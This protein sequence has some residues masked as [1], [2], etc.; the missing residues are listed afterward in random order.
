MKQVNDT[1]D[2]RRLLL[3][4]I[5][6]VRDGSVDPRTAGAISSLSCRIVQSAKLD[7]EMSRMEKAI[8][9]V[10]RPTQLTQKART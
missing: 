4:T 7:I 6:G 9:S 10:P 1:A 2:L 5:D 3:E 8:G